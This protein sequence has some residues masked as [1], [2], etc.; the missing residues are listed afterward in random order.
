MAAR[1]RTC[2]GGG[3]SDRNEKEHACNNNRAEIF[4]G[5]DL[6][7]FNVCFYKVKLI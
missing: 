4:V 5:K 7:F 3:Q 6:D 1:V 2:E